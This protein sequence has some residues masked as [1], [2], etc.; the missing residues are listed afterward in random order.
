M[1]VPIRPATDREC[2]S[3][4]NKRSATLIYGGAW[5]WLSWLD[6]SKL[7]QIRQFVRNIMGALHSNRMLFHFDPEK[8]P[9]HIPLR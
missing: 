7:S 1:E 5:W 6:I 8:M 2:G 3:M 9:V 4:T